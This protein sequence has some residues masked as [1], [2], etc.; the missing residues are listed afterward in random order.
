MARAEGSGPAAPGVR[1]AV[2]VGMAQSLRRPTEARAPGRAARMRAAR[3][4]GP[5]E[6]P[7]VVPAADGRV[8]NDCRQRG[9]TWSAAGPSRELAAPAGS[10]MAMRRKPPGYPLADQS[11][12]LRFTS[13]ARPPAPGVGSPEVKSR[14][15]AT[16]SLADSRPARPCTWNG[17]A[18]PP[19]AHER[20][21]CRKF[22]AASRK[23]A[24]VNPSPGRRASRPGRK[25]VREMADHV[26]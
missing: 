13:N 5:A 25:P 12:H 2:R 17:A 3:L 8:R 6:N 11:P 15:C 1:E 18:V 21:P 20:C 16:A 4:S 26:R 24:A 9:P 14:K 7:T 23:V 10:A 22:G 19:S